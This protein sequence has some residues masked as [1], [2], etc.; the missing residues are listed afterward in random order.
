MRQKLTDYTITM[1][2]GTRFGGKYRN[3]EH[4]RE[5]NGLFGKV[6]L[7]EQRSLFSPEEKEEIDRDK[8][9]HRAH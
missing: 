3:E 5:V 8:A 4:A 2:S 6:V 9:Y 1:A 7:V